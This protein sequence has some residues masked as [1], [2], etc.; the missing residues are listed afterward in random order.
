MSPSAYRLITRS[1]SFVARAWSTYDSSPQ[2]LRRFGG[3]GLCHRK[4]AAQEIAPLAP[5]S[6]NLDILPGL[7]ADEL[8]GGF[9][10]VR[11]EG[12]RQPLVAGNHNH[13]DIALVALRE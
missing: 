10:D 5:D 9:Q 3:A 13:Q 12:S 1:A 11:I 6:L 2:R 4:T 8:H 7:L